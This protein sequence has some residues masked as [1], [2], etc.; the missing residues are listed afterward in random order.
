VPPSCEIS[1]KATS[2]AVA[3]QVID[4]L[5]PVL[6]DHEVGFSVLHQMALVDAIAAGLVPQALREAEQYYLVLDYGDVFFAAHPGVYRRAEVGWRAIWNFFTAIWNFFTDDGDPDD[7][8]PDPRGRPVKPPVNLDWELELVGIDPEG[9]K[10]ADIDFQIR[11]FLQNLVFRQL[12]KRDPR[13]LTTPGRLKE[14]IRERAGRL[15]EEQIRAAGGVTNLTE[16][17]IAPTMEDLLG[18]PRQV[19]PDAH[20][21]PIHASDRQSVEPDADETINDMKRRQLEAAV[22]AAGGFEWTPGQ[23]PGI[24]FSPNATRKPGQILKSHVTLEEMMEPGDKPNWGW[25]DPPK[26]F[27]EEEVAAANRQAAATFAEAIG[28]A[29]ELDLD[30]E[31]EPVRDDRPCACCGGFSGS[32]SGPDPGGF[33]NIRDYEAYSA[34]RERGEERDR[35][36]LNNPCVCGQ[37]V[38]IRRVGNRAL[39]GPLE[40][41]DPEGMNLKN[42]NLVGVPLDGPDLAGANLRRADLAGANLRGSNLRGANLREAYLPLAALILADLTGAKLYKANLREANLRQANLAA[43]Y[44]READLFNS[45]LFDSILAGAN[46]RR[47]KLQEANLREAN[48]RG[49]NLTKATLHN[50]AFTGAKA[51]GDTI[52]PEGFDPVVAGVIF[53]D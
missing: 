45:N 12:R 11:L 14:G 52:W 26:G 17:V 40:T 34:Q 13:I 6:A 28:R 47:A 22:A 41:A 29:D 42:A 19:R 49:A 27:S 10:R 53:E 9:K 25:V 4:G 1:F 16:L 8:D 33:P 36:I 21:P 24:R 32:P 39:L 37:Y 46:L 48:L 30:V 3:D 50:A 35:R 20:D 5:R 18:L 43:A 31:G 15:V 44:L 38:P 23:G 2:D 51:D 7:G